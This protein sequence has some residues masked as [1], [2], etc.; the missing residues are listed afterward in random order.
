MEKKQ[1]LYRSIRADYRAQW[2][3]WQRKKQK[4]IAYIAT[5]KKKN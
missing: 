1:C 4:N 5:T 3:V 2:A